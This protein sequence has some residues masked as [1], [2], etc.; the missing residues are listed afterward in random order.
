MTAVSDEDWIRFP[1]DEP[2]TLGEPGGGLTGRVT[3]LAVVREHG[4]LRQL[5][6]TVVAD[7]DAVRAVRELLGREGSSMQGTTPNEATSVRLR[8]LPTVL[9]ALPSN[10]AA[11]RRR[12]S[13]FPFDDLGNWTLS[14]D[15]DDVE[16]SGD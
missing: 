1:L 5:D 2:V 6:M 12:L 15:R 13:R 14:P 7:R 4:R 11:L 16:P 10:V 9:P 8:L 3:E